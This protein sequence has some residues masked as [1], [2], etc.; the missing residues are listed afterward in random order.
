M[1]GCQDKTGS[2]AKV[3]SPDG[4]FYGKPLWCILIIMKVIVKIP[5]LFFLLLPAF[6]LWAERFSYTHDQGNKYRII[7]TVHESVY[8][9]RVYS[10]RAEILNRIAVEVL[11]AENG[12]GLHRAVFQTAERAEGVLGRSFQWAREYESEF[13]R[14][15]FGYLTIDSGYYMPVVRNVPV[16]PDRELN[17]GDAWSAEGY[18]AHD[19]RDS[20][21]ITEPYRIPFTANY[22][23]LGRRNWK[24][25]EYPAFSVSY[26]IFFEAPAVRGRIWP[27]RILGSSDQ[28]VYWDTAL[29]QAVAYEESFRMIFELSDGHTVEYRGSAEAEMY[30]SEL[31]DKKTIAGEIADDL[32]RLGIEDTSVRVSGGRGDK[33]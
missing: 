14:D 12:R 1:L 10:H 25:K 29:G 6:S 8:F 26:R 13:G 27:L 3:P 2:A 9:D 5:V 11:S 24:E 19:F 23:Y 22:V 16:F 21:G 32:E 31:M 17:E 20:F 30:E 33:P 4:L 18:E 7:S 28:V 15:K